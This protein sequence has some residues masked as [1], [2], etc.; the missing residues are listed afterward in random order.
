VLVADNQG[1]WQPANR[2][3]HIKYEINDDG[4]VVDKVN[5]RF[6]GHYNG[7]QRSKLFPEGGAR[8]DFMEGGE[9]PPAVW[10]PQND[11]SNSPTTPL[12]ILDGPFAGQYW[13]GELTAGA[14]GGCSSKR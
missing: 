2:L 1:A 5:G 3:N 4:S 8:A 11:V 7:L 6:F 9:Y 14:S 10:L 13:L 12:E